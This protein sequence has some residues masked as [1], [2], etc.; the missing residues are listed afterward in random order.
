MEAEVKD[1]Q[2]LKDKENLKTLDFEVKSELHKV[3]GTVSSL[4]T[5]ANVVVSEGEFQTV[6][7]DKEATELEALKWD[8]TCEAP[9][10]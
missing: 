8:V 5:Q 1:E 2:L 6:V 10:E 3:K 9:K 7:I 4:Q